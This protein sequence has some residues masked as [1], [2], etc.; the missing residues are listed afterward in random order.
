MASSAPSGSPN[1]PCSLAT[2]GQR[3]GPGK[4]RRQR[5]DV[6]LPNV[7]VLVLPF[8][9]QTCLEH[10]LH[11]RYMCAKAQGRRIMQRVSDPSSML[12]GSLAYW[13]E[14]VINDTL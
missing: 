10:L 1:S 2:Q 7:G 12:T 8:I 3:N 5:L 14:G 9:W 11:A 6:L 13:R 4:H